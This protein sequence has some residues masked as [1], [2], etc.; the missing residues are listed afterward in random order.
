M[1]LLKKSLSL[2]SKLNVLREELALELAAAQHRPAGWLP[3]TV[4]VE[5][6]EYETGFSRYEIREI[7]PD[8]TFCGVNLENGQEEILPLTD[9]NIDWLNLLFDIYACECK[10]QDLDEI[11]I[12]RCDHCGRP[13][14]KGY[15]LAGEFACSEECCLALY[16]GDASAMEEDLSHA[17]DDNADCYYTEWESFRI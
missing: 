12:R 11:E 17:D 2:S 10:V 14:M 4:Y 6:D 16:H 13:M 7:H 8:C 5:N 3:R 15:Y 9:V 1:N